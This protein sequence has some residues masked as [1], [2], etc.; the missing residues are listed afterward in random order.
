MG[1]QLLTSHPRRGLDYVS[2][3]NLCGVLGEKVDT[4]VE[5]VS[6]CVLMVLLIEQGRIK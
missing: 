1:T 5:M 3:L 2:I 4:C 6:S